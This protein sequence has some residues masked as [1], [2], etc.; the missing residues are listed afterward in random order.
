MAR[1]GD[2]ETII[3][4]NYHGHCKIVRNR[5]G[6]NLMATVGDIVQEFKKIYR[7]HP[8]YES[9]VYVRLMIQDLEE[10]SLTD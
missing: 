8:T 2:D 3:Y 6:Q 5:R 4:R 7:E 9:K 10:A 1:F